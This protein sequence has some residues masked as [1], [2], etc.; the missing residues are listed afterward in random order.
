MGTEVQAVLRAIDQSKEVGFRDEDPR[1]R[2]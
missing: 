2:A 1:T